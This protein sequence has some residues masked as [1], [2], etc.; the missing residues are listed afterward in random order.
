MIDDDEAET[1]GGRVT[2]RPLADRDQDEFLELVAASRELHRPWMKL[3]ATAQEFQ[4][5]AA[6]F[7]K[8]DDESLLICVRGTGAIAGLVNINSIIRGRF[9]NGSLSYAAF[10][11]TAGQGYMTEGL[12]LVVRHAF[13]GLRLHR[14][15]AQIQ[16]DNHA[17]IGLIR[18]V[19]FR[20][21][22][23]SPELLFID[24]AWRDHER[25]ALTTA[26][27]DGVSAEPHPTLPAR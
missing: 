13:E 9:Q 8:T 3:P 26:M 25:W 17:S 12:N 11:P 7:A 2:L 5:Y 22:G 16:P 14:L 20:Y 23:C 4:A 27:I 1:G 18:R 19:G 24:G 15:E 10:A 21:E 6:R